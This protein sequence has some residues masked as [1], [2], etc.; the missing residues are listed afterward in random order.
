MLIFLFQGAGHNDVELHP[1]YYE[2]LRKF[3]S[4]ELIKWQLKINVDGSVCNNTSDGAT[5]SNPLAASLKFSEKPP[6]T[7]AATEN[8]SNN[9][10]I[11]HDDNDG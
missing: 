7:S 9:K 10:K 2:R 8:E 11:K 4:V 1:Q 5:N 3:L 6:S